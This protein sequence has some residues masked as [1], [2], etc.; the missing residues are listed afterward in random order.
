MAETGRKKNQGRVGGRS[1]WFPMITAY[2]ACLGAIN[3]SPS[4]KT[5]VR[6]RVA[7]PTPD[8]LESQSLDFKVALEPP[9]RVPRL[10]V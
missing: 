10:A 8:A 7:C 5:D 6:G 4:C 9:Q 1:G 2:P 3:Y